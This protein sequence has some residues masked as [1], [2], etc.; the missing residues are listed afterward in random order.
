MDPDSTT[1]CLIF[2]LGYL[3]IRVL[4]TIGETVVLMVNETKM[5][6][7][8]QDGDRRAKLVCRFLQEP[9]Q[10]LTALQTAANLFGFLMMFCVA[11]TLLP[12][13]L[14]RM[15]P[16]ASSNLGGSILALIPVALLVSFLSSIL[17]IRLP[18]KI[19]ILHCEK[20]SL[21]MAHLLNGVYAISRPI[22]S[23]CFWFTDLILK[24]LHLNPY[25]LPEQVTEEEIRKM[26]DVGNEE[27]TIEQSEKDM[28]N[29]IFEFDEKTVAEVMTH[30]TEMVAVED[31]ATVF[32]TAKVAIEEGFSRI[33]VYH[34]DIDDVV[35]VLYA[36][37]LLQYVEGSCSETER[38]DRFMRKVLFVPESNRCTELFNTFKT[39]KIH[40]AIVVDE[41]GGTSGLVT[42]E[43]LLE[44][45]VGNMQDEYDDE[46]EEFIKISP[47]EYILDGSL[48]IEDTE[49]ILNV[50]LEEEAEEY[51]T[52]SG[53]I[54]DLL[55]R[56]PEE[57]E[58]PSVEVK[59]LRLSVLMAKERRILKVRAEILKPVMARDEK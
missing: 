10:F 46:E 20:V 34:E 13:I 38:I 53:L 33:P 32:E 5:E 1:Y 29:N 30:R 36:K 37:D 43:D 35:G 56:I 18:Q 41:Y 6:H 15:H 52:L 45:I 42:M 16:A 57:Q 11:Q 40:M 55:E 23:L 26:V 59:N 24:A 9:E 49:K 31:T 4:L 19:T 50:E 51:D 27:G 3:L 39:K 25:D 14:E 47:T 44:S 2:F 8:A 58:H 7:M 28:I 48:S 54:I 12:P 21:S 22:A 17:V